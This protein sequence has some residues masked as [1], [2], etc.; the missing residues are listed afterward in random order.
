VVVVDHSDIQHSSN[1]LSNLLYKTNN[2]DPF[3]LRGRRRPFGHRHTSNLLSSLLYKKITLTP[4][5][6]WC[7]VC[8]VVVDHSDIQHSS[9]LLSNLLYKTNNAD[10]F[11]FLTPLIF[12]KRTVGKFNRLVSIDSTVQ[13]SSKVVLRNFG[14]F[15]AK[16]VFRS[17]HLNNSVR[18]GLRIKPASGKQ[19]VFAIFTDTL[20]E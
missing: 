15:I 13:N 16:A 8:V 17:D 6:H 11:N 18:Y 1:L 14:G 9:N 12:Y 2:A 7:G 10:P 3:N 20:P 4:L 5:I 19:S